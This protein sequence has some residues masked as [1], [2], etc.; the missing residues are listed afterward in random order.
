MTTKTAKYTPGPWR[1]EWGHIQANEGANI[2]AMNRKDL[3]RS[4][5]EQDANAYLITA[6]PE[7]LEAC[8]AAFHEGILG[9]GR[10]SKKVKQAI[11]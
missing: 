10:A 1:L 8:K 6:A 5:M 3:F 7:L 9:D 2:A 4:T 11:S